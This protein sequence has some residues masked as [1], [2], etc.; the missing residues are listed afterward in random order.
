MNHNEKD[1][2]RSGLSLI[3]KVSLIGGGFY[4]LLFGICAI[5]FA[6]AQPEAGHTRPQ[7][8]QHQ[9]PTVRPAPSQGGQVDESV[10]WQNNAV[11]D[12][13]DAAS[14]LVPPLTLRWSRDLSANGVT[15]ISYPLIAQGL[16][17]VTT[18]GQANTLMAL[19]ENTGAT[20]WSAAINGTYGFVNAAYDSGKVFVVNFDGLM[21]AFDAA[22]G[23]LLWSVSLPGQYAF[24]S[25]PTAANGI[26]YEGGA[27]SGGT[28]YA[29][30][31]TNGAVLWTMPVEN[32]DH[33]SPAV[34][35]GSVFVSYACPQSYAFNAT[36]GQQLWHYSSCCEGGGGAT[37]VV[38][39]GQVYVRDDFC[40]QTSGLVL[41][42]NTGTVIGGFNSDRPPAFVGNL[43][44][45]FQSGTLRGVENGQ[46]LWS[47]AG[48]GQLT[49][50][51]VIVNQT[52]YIGSNSGTLFGLNTS[53]QQIWSTQVGAPIPAPD[54][55]N[56]TL[57]TGLGAGD[58]LLVVPTAS[59]LV[60]YGT[61]LTLTGAVSRKTHG[62]A[63][64]FDINM[65]LTGSSGIEC[66]SGGATHDYSLVATFSSNVNVTGMPQ[67]QVI[68]GSGCVGSGGVC[69]PNGTVSVSGNIVTVPLTNIA[70]AQVINVQING[71][72]GAGD[73]PAVNVNIPVGI[74]IGDVNGN[75][76][77][78]ASDVALTKSQVGQNVGAG[79]FRE[80][81]NAN[82][83]ISSTD[84]AIVKSDVGTSLPP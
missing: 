32:G 68:T 37:P 41:D 81:V 84:V 73:E 62:A 50:A 4:L 60:A 65:P 46:V 29:V 40:D 67:A 78:N 10:A 79:N 19:D 42:A 61:P 25:P 27:G 83:T 52:I 58:G 39:A 77:V 75:R 59:I 53:G 70:D 5:P 51:P 1:G 21:K 48:D 63:G 28:V 35:A 64:T 3:I 18:T 31:E 76:A 74:L 8:Q 71:V 44:L 80:D 55:G 45:Y 15:S 43:A 16:V 69:D 13:F 30:N 26:V 49:S 14:P 66:R 72:N 2:R 17:L 12:G 34:V 9:Q 33:S 82:G 23:T 54:E 57:T 24:T 36:T 11:H 38:H 47:F 20:V 7:L 6:V 56:A 22:T